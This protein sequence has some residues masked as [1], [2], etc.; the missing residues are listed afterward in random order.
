MPLY[1]NTL[2]AQTG[3]ALGDIRLL[4][5]Q[6]RRSIK[7]RSPYELWRDDQPAFE[8][9][10]GTQSFGNRQKLR[11]AYWASFV[12]TPAGETLLAGFYRCTYLGISTADR[13]WPHAAGVDPAGS[14]DNYNLTLDEQLNDLA[15]RLLIDWGASERAWIQRADNQNK[16]VL[17]I[18]P[19]FREPVFPGFQ[20]FVEPLS[21]VERLPDSW[22]SALSSA[23]GVYLLTCSKT[24]EQY[25]G[26][27][28]GEG[29]FYGRWLAYVYDGHGGNV[30]LKRRDPSDYQ[31]SI[32]EVAGSSATIE[33]IIAMEGL[34]KR[35]LQ[36]REMGLNRN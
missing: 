25:V 6:D 27:A 7:G 18:R 29:G 4:R 35:K 13:P 30:G 14:C 15:G 21:K 8:L 17:E 36:S 2:F 9:Y 12:T 1:L 28:Y 16:L 20:R 3:I 34:W 23:R 10:Q 11:A 33:N 24:R 32:L 26:S 22:K 5:H 31:V 19:A